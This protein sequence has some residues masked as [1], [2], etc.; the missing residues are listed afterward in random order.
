MRMRVVAH[1]ES[2][3]SYICNWI[4]ACAPVGIG[5]MCLLITENLITLKSVMAQLVCEQ[6][7]QSN[8]YLKKTRHIWHKK[9][10]LNN[11]LMKC[12]LSC[13]KMNY[14][15]LVFVYRCLF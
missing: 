3:G 11:S 10:I 12:F 1:I 2:K 8:E 4:T 7:R 13:H 5:F 14:N 6:A 15:Y 9:F